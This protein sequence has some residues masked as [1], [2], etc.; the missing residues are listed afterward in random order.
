MLL[1][2]QRQSKIRNSSEVTDVSK[3]IHGV[4][5][6][7]SKIRSNPRIWCFKSSQAKKC[8]KD[9]NITVFSWHIMTRYYAA[10]KWTLFFL[11]WLPGS[12]EYTFLG[13][14]AQT[15]TFSKQKFDSSMQILHT[16]PI[17]PKKWSDHVYPLGIIYKILSLR[18]PKGME[19]LLCVHCG[20][21]VLN[22]FGKS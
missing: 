22:M 13:K 15:L 6:T 10:K 5:L 17:S 2:K 1:L 8:Y 16:R 12:T 9:I 11:S 14:V 19:L 18:S 7:L 21:T 20:V 4:Y 3:Q